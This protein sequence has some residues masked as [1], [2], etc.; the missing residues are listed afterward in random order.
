MF[1][2]QQYKKNKRGVNSKI[3]GARIMCR[4]QILLGVVNLVTRGGPYSMKWF[5]PK[6]QLLL[7]LKCYDE[8]ACFFSSFFHLPGHFLGK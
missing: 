4:I 1:I 3:G 2:K 6:V 7:D 5:S 8:S